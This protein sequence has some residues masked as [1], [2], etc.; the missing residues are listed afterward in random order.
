[1]KL[2]AM[3]ERLKDNSENKPRA[4]RRI[5]G[6]GTDQYFLDRRR[7]LYGLVQQNT[8]IPAGTQTSAL[9]MIK[10]SE[11]A[12]QLQNVVDKL[13]AHKV[14]AE[15]V[16]PI[17]QTGLFRK[18]LTP[19]QE[20]AI[21]DIQKR[22]AE[23]PSRKSQQLTTLAAK[24]KQASDNN[25]ADPAPR[26]SEGLFNWKPKV[27]PAEGTIEKGRRLEAEAHEKYK[28]EAR[29][30]FHN[31]NYETMS[32]KDIEQSARNIVAG[33]IRIGLNDDLQTDYKALAS[34][35]SKS[36]EYKKAAAAYKER[37]PKEFDEFKSRV[38]RTIKPSFD[39]LKAHWKADPMSF[40]VAAEQYKAAQ[41]GIEHKP[42]D[43]DAHTQKQN[44]KESAYR[45]NVNKEKIKKVTTH[46]YSPD[47]H[48]TD[49]SHADELAHVR[50]DKEQQKLDVEHADHYD[51]NTKLSARQRIA[52]RNGWPS[53]VGLY[54][55]HQ[56][57]HTPAEWAHSPDNPKRK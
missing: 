32:A 40:R 20:E 45:D 57:K 54:G 50:K 49:W 25:Q 15:S 29:R 43:W 18:K 5:G 14:I 31:R 47:P 21:R 56:Y 11:T 22:K 53:R 34:I 36:P 42:F 2:T 35:I 3:T 37:Y 48:K 44:D 13:K 4:D 46:A 27:K 28:E 24:M 6:E 8:N 26:L 23:I 39:N 51:V 16:E 12:E 17:R 10:K 9:N 33:Y 7:H 38:G 55:E 19:G 52:V 30:V 41:S 1:M